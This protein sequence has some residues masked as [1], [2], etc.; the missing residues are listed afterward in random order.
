MRYNVNKK[1]PWEELIADFPLIDTDL[2]ENNASNN[3]LIIACVFVAAVTS[4]RWHSFEQR[5][6]IRRENARTY[7]K[8]DN[9]RTYVRVYSVEPYK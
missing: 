4:S 8:S 7:V 3:S 9:A 6:V 1:K 5:G 2:I